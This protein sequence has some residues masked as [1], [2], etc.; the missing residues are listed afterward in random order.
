MNNSEKQAFPS[1]T[2]YGMTK[3]EYFAGLAMQRLI[4][5]SNYDDYESVA[6]MS[7][8]YADALLKALEQKT[9]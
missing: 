9:E 4:V 7:I 6:K 8:K 5:R 2:H 3:R 1:D